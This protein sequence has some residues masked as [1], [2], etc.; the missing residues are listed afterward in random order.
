MFKFRRLF[1]RKFN[2]LLA[3]LSLS[4]VVFFAACAQP[5]P[6]ATTTED[7]A[8][9]TSMPSEFRIGY[10]VIPN[11]EVLM[12]N[13]GIVEEKFPDVEIKW[14]SFDSGRDVN[15]AM[16]SGGIDVGLVG[17]VPASTGIAQDLPY[18]VYV[19]HDVI[20]DNEA[21]AV[22][23][24][25]GITSM[26]DLSG[27]KIGVPFGS[28]THFSLLSALDKEGIPAADVQVLD[29][30]PQDM[31]AAWQR[32]DIDGGFVWH[33]TLSRMIE[34]DGKVL[35]TAKEL[36]AE[37][38]ITA[39]LGVVNKE[40]AATY[41]DMLTGY[42]ESLDEAVQF[43]RKDPEAAAEAIS[44]EIGLSPEESLAVMNELV[45]VS[46]DEQASSQYLGTPEEPG[47]L[48]QVLKDSAEFMVAQGAIPSA[49][50]LEAYQAAIFNKAV[51]D[52]TASK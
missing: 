28:T 45:W 23:A 1:R 5:T 49:P 46:A 19:I 11:A 32:G 2:A 37:G 26:A 42:V 30:Q 43:Y 48:G 39:D 41:P 12:K 15:T 21:L 10:Q 25:S 31:L 35:I 6:E 22:T 51:A 27:K 44:Q 3:L 16:V 29:M 9:A 4:L 7:V 36:A 40:F 8:A 33:P 13:M 34:Q 17:S 14:L 38:I 50:D 52:V 24:G 18:Q 47:A 20:G